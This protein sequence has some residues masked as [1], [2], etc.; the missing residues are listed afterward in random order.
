MNE[1]STSSNGK[2]EEQKDELT[3]LKENLKECQDKYLRTLAESEKY[4]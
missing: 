3:L 2:Q 4:P 1:E